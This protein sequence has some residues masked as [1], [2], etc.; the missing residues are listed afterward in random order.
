MFP[1][2]SRYLEWAI[3]GEALASG[4]VWTLPELPATGDR[5]TRYRSGSATV[6]DA[7]VTVQ[8]GISSV[9]RP[10]ILRVAA[11]IAPLVRSVIES[12]GSHHLV[13]GAALPEAI[14]W[15]ADH[16]TRQHIA[17]AG[18]TGRRHCLGNR[19]FHRAKGERKK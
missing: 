1:I 3:L 8:A 13:D 15:G 12:A 19:H 9:T 6:L 14:A 18:W 16:R 4:E 5:R 17:D 7:G 2:I 10:R 11:R